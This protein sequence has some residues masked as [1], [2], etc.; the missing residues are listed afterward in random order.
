MDEEVPGAAVDAAAAAARALMR[1]Q[2]AGEE[3][4]VEEMARAAILTA[5]RFCG[6]VLVP[7]AGIAARDGWAA[8][9]AP[10]RQGV[11]MLVQHLAEGAA[12]GGDAVPPVA[13]A[14]LWRP[15]RTTRLA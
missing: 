10:V 3:A 7:R 13:V 8:V 15:F 6:R 4:V 5:E 9:P 14:A 12:G 1:G 11:A 2:A